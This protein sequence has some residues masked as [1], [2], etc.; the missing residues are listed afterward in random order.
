[1]PTIVILAAGLGSRYGGNK[2]LV[3]LGH[4]KL[5][6]MEYNLLHAVEAGFDRVVFVIRPELSELINRQVIPRLP[7]EL[8]HHIVFQT[9]DNVPINCLTPKSRTKP[10]GTAHALWCCKDLLK[11]HFAVINADDYYGEQA[12]KLLLSAA[13]ESKNAHLMVAY[14]LGNTLS[15]YGGVNRGLC[16]LTKHNTLNYIEECE[17]IMQQGP[18]IV[19]TLTNSQKTIT[20]EFKSLISMNCWYFNS[21]IIP[22]LEAEVIHL[23]ADNNNSDKAECFLPEVVMKQVR[24]QNKP[25]ITLTT[26][27][28]WFGL[29]YPQDTDAIAKK[30]LQLELKK[31]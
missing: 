23:L 4:K 10:L 17:N 18:R 5:T 15:H 21:D 14:Q 11:R 13:N 22:F 25:V 30:I 20:L 8:A 3:E 19:G 29:T 9:L 28:R 27:D 6:L 2:Q 1:M 26:N 12:F 16:K 7:T 31:R 24:A